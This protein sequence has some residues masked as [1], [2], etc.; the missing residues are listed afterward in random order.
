MLP[1]H[2]H[3]SDQRRFQ[4]EGLAFGKQ[5]HATSMHFEDALC[6][7]DITPLDQRGK[8]FD[9]EAARQRVKK[10]DIP[11]NTIAD[12][13][14]ASHARHG[15]L[16]EKSIAHSDSLLINPQNATSPSIEDDYRIETCLQYDAPFEL[17]LTHRLHVAVTKTPAIETE[18]HICQGHHEEKTCSIGKREAT[19]KRYKKKL[20]SDSTIQSYQVSK[21]HGY[22]AISMQWKHHDNMATCSNSKI[23]KRVLKE[24]LSDIHEAWVADNSESEK[25]AQSQNCTFIKSTK[26]TPEPRQMNEMD[27][28]RSWLKTDLYMCRHD[29]AKCPF[30]NS[31]LCVQKDKRCIQ[32]AGDQCAVWELTFK[33]KVGKHAISK[34]S[35]ENTYGVHKDLLETNYPPNSSFTEAVTKLQIFEEMKREFEKSNQPNIAHVELFG[36]KK[37]QCSKS[38]AGDMLYDCCFSLRGLANTLKLSKCTADELALAEMREKGM[39]YYLG[40]HKDAFLELWNSRTQHVY[41]C[42]PSKLARVLQQEG[43]KQLG[44]DWGSA[45]EPNCRGLTQEEIRR[46]DLAKIDLSE[47]YNTPPSIDMTERLK[48]IQERLEKRLAECAESAGQQ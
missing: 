17:E 8:T 32:S 39:C 7:E 2:V 23:E 27:I 33:C 6:I 47:A 31:Y 29:Q 21:I 28:T 30:L 16:D 46:L 19:L 10:Q 48:G 11:E 34:N 38:L 3:A 45:K 41:C 18:V 35:T 5:M 40:S 1:L 43:R 24:G 20:A 13:S 14:R 36:G 9:A 22:P 37:S 42:F 15:A 26:S 12:L 44:I 25:L 4:E